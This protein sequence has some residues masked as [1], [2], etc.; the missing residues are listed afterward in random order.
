MHTMLCSAVI[1]LARFVHLLRCVLGRRDTLLHAASRLR[2][3]LRQYGR[4]HN[5]SDYLPARRAR[6]DS[7]VMFGATS[8]SSGRLLE[9]TTFVPTGV[10][11]TYHIRAFDCWLI[12]LH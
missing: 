12:D 3:S 10:P 1:M 9:L 8:G 2:E 6:H 5:S 7:T 4:F 11:K